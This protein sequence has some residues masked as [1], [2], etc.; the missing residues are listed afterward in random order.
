[1]ETML[2]FTHTLVLV[3]RILR[4]RQGIMHVPRA[5]AQTRSLFTSGHNS[6]ASGI[7]FIQG[8]H[9]SKKADASRQL[10]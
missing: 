4:V 9:M 8:L 1:M 7:N 5:Y 10:R 2:T 6:V 3:L